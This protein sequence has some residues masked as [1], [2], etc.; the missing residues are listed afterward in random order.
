MAAVGLIA[1][2]AAASA[3]AAIREFNLNIPRQPLD[4]ALNDLAHQTG[5]QVGRFSD[6][7]DGATV[8][9]PLSGKYSA[10]VALTRLLEPSGLTFRPLNERA[11]IVLN[12]EDHAESVPALN[13]QVGRGAPSSGGGGAS[14][15]H[16]AAVTPGKADDPPPSSSDRGGADESAAASSRSG[17]A[18]GASSG[19]DEA[20]LDTVVVT[21]RK[22]AETLQDVPLS[23]S[24]LDADMLD[25]LH[26]K[27]AND[28][29]GLVPGLYYSNSGGVT[30]NS[31]FIYLTIRG[32]G[33]NSGQE[34]ATG[35]FIDGMYQPQLG[36]DIDL[37]DLE[38]LE[39]LRGPQGTLFGRNTEAGALNLVTRKPGEDV[40]GR[41]ELEG[42][43]FN[44]YR[45][46][47]SV[48]GPISDTLFAGIA[49]Q[50]RETDGYMTNTAINDPAAHERKYAAR[51]TLRWVPSDSLR[52]DLA[53]D[54]S[55]RDGRE[56]DFGSPIDCRCY[57]LQN[58][59]RP[60]NSQLN[61]GV[62]L[63]AEWKAT[64][65]LT[66][67]SI[68]GYREVKTTTHAEFDG[69]VTDQSVFVANGL[70]DSPLV[71]P[72]V[73]IQGDGQDLNTRQSFWSEEL[74]LGSTSEGLDWLIGAYY[75]EQDQDNLAEQEVGPGVVT[76]P[77]IAFLVPLWDRENFAANR[78][79]WAL[80]AQ[81]SWRPVDRL[82]LT[83]G[84]RYSEESVSNDGFFFINFVPITND[85][86]VFFTAS[87]EKSFSNVS[88]TVSVSWEFAP[89]VKGYVTVA[90]GWK[91]GG[92]S[93]Y[94]ST[95][96]AAVQPY[97]DETS[98]NYEVG[99]KAAWPESRISANFALFRIDLEDQQLF[100]TTTNPNGIPVSTITNAG[101]SRSQGAE[102]E[103]FAQLAE[104]LELS[105][106]VS[107]T[108]TEF[109]DFTQTAA[110]GSFVVR[111]G[112]RFEFV[113]LLTGAASVQYRVPVGAGKQLTLGAT[114]RYAGDYMVPDTAILAPLGNQLGVPSSS[115]LDFGASL[116]FDDWKLSAYVRNALDSFDYSNVA[117]RP[118]LAESPDTRLVRPLAPRNYGIVISKNF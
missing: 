76:D 85:A 33:F 80:F 89:T 3:Q 117:Y 5:L 65:S 51:G 57:S 17:Q 82:E 106:S 50:Y 52:F 45:A 21:A 25:E 26:I 22:R 114:Y 44:T 53:A 104:P 14:G 116:E 27:S 46:L 72:E 6:S 84:L 1:L 113:P 92:F 59:P 12:P 20:R 32:V 40:Q 109:L 29:Y 107:Y 28:L 105:L 8:V 103:L 9:G 111:D 86:P 37:L 4:S 30:Q 36:Y 47:G 77:N 63:N 48:S 96:E 88:P 11:F 102:L 95:P 18:S 71:P 83:G 97:D 100:T 13:S 39:V 99:L 90:E 67:E 62:Q 69:V 70:P 108:D 56:M 91:A 66:L 55:D 118:F 81:A 74:R 16:D 87:A 24:V 94:P 112:Q 38:R 35:V 19:P 7:V 93:R 42:A 68:T 61:R 23:V 98:V 75:F 64:S 110:D 15:S 34:P 58:D 43:R 79:G 2:G 41:L 73:P 49:A 54:Y 10:D 60:D 115:S 78:D 101:E 31:D